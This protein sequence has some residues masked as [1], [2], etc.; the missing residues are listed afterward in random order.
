M[1]MLT[2]D[3]RQGVAPAPRGGTCM[4]INALRM[5]GLAGYRQRRMTGGTLMSTAAATDSALLPETASL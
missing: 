4:L 1:V 2:V 3:G 5:T